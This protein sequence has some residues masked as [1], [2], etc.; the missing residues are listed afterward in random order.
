MCVFSACSEIFNILN[1]EVVHVLRASSGMTS[2]GQ[3]KLIFPRERKG[4]VKQ[5]SRLSVARVQYNNFRISR[6]FV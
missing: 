3:E 4:L 5:R 1:V 2:E 6:S